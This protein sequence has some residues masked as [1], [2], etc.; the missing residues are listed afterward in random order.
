LA[1]GGEHLIPYVRTSQDLKSLR[2]DLQTHGLEFG[3]HLIMQGSQKACVNGKI[4]GEYIKSVCLPYVAKVQSER[5]IEREEAVLLVDNCPGHLT[6]EVLA[7]LTTA[8]VRIVQFSLYTMHIFQLINPTL[9][10]TFK[11]VGKYRLPFND[12][13]LASHFICRLSMDFNGR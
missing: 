2:V 5:E 10:G 11:R 7:V 3:R 12:L 4:F 9:S 1:A 8:R 6:S 13:T